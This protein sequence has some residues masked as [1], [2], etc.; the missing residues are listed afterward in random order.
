M[1]IIIIPYWK[2]GN[3]GE[4]FFSVCCELEKGTGRRGLSHKASCLCKK[5][6]PRAGKGLFSREA[7]G[8]LAWERAWRGRSAWEPSGV[9]GLDRIGFQCQRPSRRDHDAFDSH[10][11]SEQR[12]CELPQSLTVAGRVKTWQFCCL[13]F[14]LTLSLSGR[15]A[16]SKRIQLPF[17]LPRNRDTR[18]DQR[19]PVA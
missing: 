15:C 10:I 5:L 19:E 7:G 12:R 16:Q 8:F 3:R 4:R 11:Q 13:S 1:R 9:A 6:K 2:V 14:I 18:I 17:E